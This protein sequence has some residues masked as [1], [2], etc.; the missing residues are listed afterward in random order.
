VD[1]H[2]YRRAEK[3]RAALWPVDAMDQEGVTVW[4]SEQM[5]E[6]LRIARRIAPT[7][8]SVL[9]TGETGTG[10]E[11]LA[12][13]IHRAS[14][15][16]ERPFLPFN[17]SAVP[18][19]MVE[20]QLFG[21]RKGAFTGADASFPGVI[22]SA[23]GGTLFLDEIADVPL[24]VQPKLLRF[25]ETREIHPLGESQP[26]QVD[27]RIVAA[28]NANLEHLVAAGRFRE[29]LFYRLNVV[30]LTLP[31]LRERREE[32][33][34]LVQHYL[35]KYGDE[36]KK[37]Q[38]ALADETLEYLLLYGW[39]GNV[40]QLANEVR[41]MVALVEPDS[42]LTPAALSPELQASRRTIPA[43]AAAAAQGEPEIRLRLDQPLPLAVEMLEQTMIRSALKRSRGR[44][45]EAAK[46]LGIS[47]KGL[48]LKRRRWNLDQKQAS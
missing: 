15:R 7:P 27:V 47:R 46:L 17:C 44:V 12:R 33:P 21:Y 45:E 48:F 31:P 38:L 19:D 23:A 20:S 43:A 4:V 26:T 42:T 35:R 30:R 36:Q 37:G 25:L 9:L 3:Q 13:E 8:L 2:R 18:R 32:I 6:V 1:L 40:R 39:P 29:D 5:S 24:D 28:T 14:D 34:A 22:R 16:A 10:K 41:R 11:M